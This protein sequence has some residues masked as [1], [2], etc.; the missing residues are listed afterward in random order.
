[1]NNTYGDISELIL[2]KATKLNNAVLESCIL[3]DVDFSKFNIDGMTISF[4]ESALDF[5]LPNNSKGLIFNFNN[6]ENINLNN[7]SPGETFKDICEAKNIDKAKNYK[8]NSSGKK[9]FP[10][11]ILIMVNF[12]V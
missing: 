7:L 2:N 6:L 1:M 8:L 5:K 10:L 9:I 4:L 12:E 11:L 3:D